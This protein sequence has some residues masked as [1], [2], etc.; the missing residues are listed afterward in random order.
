M[1]ICRIESIEDGISVEQDLLPLL[2]N[3]TG[4]DL[5]SGNKLQIADRKV[6]YD[7]KFFILLNGGILLQ[8]FP[9]LDSKVVEQIM[10]GEYDY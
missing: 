4:V 2:F 6:Y 8:E 1:Y 3:I 7:V 5:L 10:D 9:V